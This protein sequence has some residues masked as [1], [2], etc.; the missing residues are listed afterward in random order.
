MKLKITVDVNPERSGYK[1]DDELKNNI[2]D[3][4]YE[5]LVHGA[6]SRNVDFAVRSVKMKNRKRNHKEVNKWLY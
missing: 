4:V 5:W 2:A 1:T 6:E 3:F